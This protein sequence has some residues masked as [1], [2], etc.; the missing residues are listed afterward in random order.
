LSVVLGTLVAAAALA[1]GPIGSLTPVSG[2][3][4]C[5]VAQNAPAAI[6]CTRVRELRSDA[7]LVSPDSRNLYTLGGIDDRS[8]LAVMHRDPRTGAVRQL[9]GRGGCLVAIWGG[10]HTFPNCTGAYLNKPNALAMTPDGRELVYLNPVGGGRHPVNAYKR[11]PET[12]VL[13]PAGCCGAVRGVGCPSDVATSPD[14]RNVY[15][16]SSTCTG[17]GLS[18]LVRDPATGTLSQPAGK[19]G[20]IQRIGADGCARAPTTSF[21]PEEV[22]V[23]ADGAEVYV[24]AGGL[25]MFARTSTGLLKL[26]ACY[27][28]KAARPCRAF[29]DLWGDEG[30]F[31]GFLLAPDGRNLYAEVP[32][33]I[34]VLARG[35]SGELSQLPPP[36]GCVSRT[37]DGGRCVAAPGLPRDPG[38]VAASA[39]GRTVY[40]AG[41]VALNR[42]RSDGSLSPLPGRYG[43]ASFDAELAYALSPDGRSVYVAGDLKADVFGYRILRRQTG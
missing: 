11:S 2:P 17:H 4:G 9:S 21:S 33:R 20:C 43:R 40:A 30:A 38:L 19:A 12:G 36:R 3:Q 18:I 29:A 14:G 15:I 24:V 7:A 28:S 31:T 8:A 37:G 10:R 32:G 27:F 6:H 22:A 16:A 35:H 1:A 13:S 34:L 5:L 25:F 26:R 39:D 23:T 42:D 41:F